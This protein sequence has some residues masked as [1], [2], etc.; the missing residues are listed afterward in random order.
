[1]LTVWF[2]LQVASL[3]ERVGGIVPVDFALKHSVAFA[4]AINAEGSLEPLTPE[5]LRALINSFGPDR[6]CPALG[7]NPRLS[8]ASLRATSSL[9]GFQFSFSHLTF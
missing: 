1:M 4:N 9:L 6:S 7:I 2:S 8:L 3:L 5:E